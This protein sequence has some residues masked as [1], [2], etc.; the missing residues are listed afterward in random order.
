[1]LIDLT[2]TKPKTTVPQANTIYI[3]ILF[4][5]LVYPFWGHYKLIP[6]LRGFESIPIDVLQIEPPN[7]VS[8]HVQKAKQTLYNM[9]LF[10]QCMDD[11]YNFSVLIVSMCKYSTINLFWNIG[12]LNTC[13]Y[14]YIYTWC[15]GTTQEKDLRLPG[16]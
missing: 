5:L 7:L 11:P 6:H 16:I 9:N 3:Y 15:H 1:M 8:M 12:Y 10:M 4:F 14:I 13:I 2:S